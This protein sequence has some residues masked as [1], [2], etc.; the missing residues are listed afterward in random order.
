MHPFPYR[1]NASAASLPIFPAFGEVMQNVKAHPSMRLLL[2]GPSALGSLQPHERHEHAVR[3]MCWD[4]LKR[5]SPHEHERQARE[6]GRKNSERLLGLLRAHDPL[7][8]RTWDMLHHMFEILPDAA[9][10]LIKKGSHTD[11][12]IFLELYEEM[13]ALAQEVEL[14]G[15]RRK[16]SSLGEPRS[17]RSGSF[18]STSAS[19]QARRALVAKFKSGRAEEGDFLKY[20]EL[21]SEETRFFAEGAG[22]RS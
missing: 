10:Y 14:R 1:T 13:R 20:L 16:H 8:E 11:P 22:G 3:C 15:H 7:F 21:C 9:E 5:T 19:D 12:A 18:A 4:H 2:E 6:Q 17:G